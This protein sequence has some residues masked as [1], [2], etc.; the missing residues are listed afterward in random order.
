MKRR[1]LGRAARIAAL[2][3]GAAA[4]AGPALADVAFT[5]D[6]LGRLA[7]A[8]YTQSGGT[9]TVTYSYD[10]NGNRLIAAVTSNPSTGIWGTLVWG[11]G[12]W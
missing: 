1:G 11:S 7:T 4:L 3:L 2:A 9:V 8:V 10:E 5:Y 6:S 12:V